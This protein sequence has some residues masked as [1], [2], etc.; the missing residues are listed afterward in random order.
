MNDGGTLDIWIV[1]ALGGTPRKLVSD[2]TDPA[3]SADGRSLAYVNL[4]TTSLWLCDANG[5]NARA[6]TKP[7]AGI[8]PRQPVF[9]RDGQR[10]AFEWRRSGPRGEL[11]VLDLR[12]QQVH[13]LTNDGMVALSPAWSRDDRFLYFSSSRGGAMNIWKMASGGGQPQQVTTGQGDDAELDLSRDGKRLVFSTYRVNVD[14]GEVPLDAGGG[15]DRSGSRSV[16]WLTRDATRGE[17]AP[18]YSRDGSRVAYFSNRRGAEPETLWIMNADGSSAAQ[19][20][21]DGRVSVYPRW[22]ADGQSVLF[23]SRGGFNQVDLRRIQVS[24]GQP[25][26]LRS[27]EAFGIPWG[28]VAMNGQAIY[29]DASGNAH[30]LDLKRR[31]DQI[32]QPVRGTHFRWARDGGL[33]AYKRS[34][35]RA[36][37]PDAGVWLYDFHHPPR[38]LFTGWVLWQEWTHSGDLLV[39]QGRSDLSALLWRIRPD[40]S[41]PAR[42][43]TL[44]TYFTYYVQLNWLLM[45][46]VHPDGRR[47][48]APLLEA[49]EA[50]IGMI[51]NVQ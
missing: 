17:L 33:L 37:D 11:A 1:P 36:G 43:I 42:S 12:T 34:P 3:W 51:E 44:P 13:R 10:L 2:A 19:I 4:E 28:D 45:F 47:I 35:K 48:I 15:P 40:G 21:E 16:K 27:S 30:I 14:L 38:Q 7:E 18:A 25:E 49:H 41:A 24:G 50:D 8:S 6:L 31:Q 32:L 46:D 22:T 9:S 5:G 23:M 26:T 29:G 39:A 20:L